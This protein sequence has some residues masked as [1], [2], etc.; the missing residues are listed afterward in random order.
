MAHISVS[1]HPGFFFFFFWCCVIAALGHEY[2]EFSH[3]HQDVNLTVWSQP[4]Q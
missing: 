4:A 3:P 2:S 1:S